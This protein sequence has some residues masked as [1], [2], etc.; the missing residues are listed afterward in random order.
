[1]EWLLHYETK[2]LHTGSLL[3]ALAVFLMLWFKY[4]FTAEFFYFVMLDFGRKDI[5]IIQE[6][7]LTSKEPCKTGPF[8]INIL[9][10][11]WKKD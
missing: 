1:M 5:S 9:D 6:S 7:A 3:D 4:K 8:K 2:W 11:Q 10:T